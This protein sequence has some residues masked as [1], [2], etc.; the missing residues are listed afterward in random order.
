MIVVFGSLNVD[1][2]AEMA[3]APKAGQTIPAEAFRMEAGGKGA[4]QALAATRAGAE[5][6]MAGAV[7]RDPLADIALRALRAAGIDLANVRDVD[8]VT[9]TATIWI[10]RCGQN[11][12]VVAAGANAMARADTVDDATLARAS[13]VLLQMEVP[14]SETIAMIRRC[15]ANGVRSILN[16]A[17]ALPFAREELAACGLLVVNEDEAEDLAGWLGCGA[18]AAAIHAALGCD[19]IR[20]LGSLGAEAA[21]REGHWATPA[22]AV[23][24]VDTTAAGD[25]FFGALAA[26][27][28]RRLF[29]RAAMAEASVAAALACTRKG[30][31]AS[32]PM[33][34]EI[35][36]AIRATHS[37]DP[38]Q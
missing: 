11:R 8:A 13:S 1:L 18:D 10:E 25:C 35:D 17:P 5:V 36:A 34:A 24:V 3:A 33:R 9:G 14:Q 21:T 22:H 32:L 4:N 15:K 7:G 37:A 28:D 27:L 30:A 19:V 23:A 20:T 31:Q 2:V 29:L 26:G 38:R 16:L 12:I 6:V